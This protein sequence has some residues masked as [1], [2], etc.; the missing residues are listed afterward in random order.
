VL[1]SS[2]LFTADPLPLTHKLKSQSPN[3]ATASGREKNEENVKLDLK[4]SLV[5]NHTFVRLNK[6]YSMSALNDVDFCYIN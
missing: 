3:P 6:K 5:L 4:T 2:A 1:P